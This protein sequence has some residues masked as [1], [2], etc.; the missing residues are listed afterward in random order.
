MTSMEWEKQ[1]FYEILFPK[2]VTSYDCVN[3]TF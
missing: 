3:E 2:K 1:S